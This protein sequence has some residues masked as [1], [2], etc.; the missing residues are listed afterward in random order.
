MGEL[1][2]YENVIFFF[3]GDGNDLVG[4]TTIL[5]S[6][7]LVHVQ[8]NQTIHQLNPVNR[9]SAPICKYM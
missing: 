5:L 2:N 7:A 6:L 3:A 1:E 9:I 8:P 4:P